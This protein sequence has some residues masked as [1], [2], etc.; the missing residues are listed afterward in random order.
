MNAIP[1]LVTGFIRRLARSKSFAPGTCIA[2]TFI[3][4]MLYHQ[5]T[6]WRAIACSAAFGSKRWKSTVVAPAC[7]V[8]FTPISMPAM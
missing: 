1:K 7:T 5:V 4:A 3:G 2:A 8:M 6:R